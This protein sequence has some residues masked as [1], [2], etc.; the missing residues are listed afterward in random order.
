M[1]L[2]SLVMLSHEPFTC[3]WKPCVP[4]GKPFSSGVKD[5]VFAGLSLQF[6]LTDP[7][8]DRSFQHSLL[9]QKPEKEIRASAASHVVLFILLRPFIVICTIRLLLKGFL[10]I[11]PPIQQILSN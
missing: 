10:W 3:T 8:Q 5:S 6:R 1:I 2:P 7:S 9:Q 11:E 4:V